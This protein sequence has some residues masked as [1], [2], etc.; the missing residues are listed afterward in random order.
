MKRLRYMVWGGVVAGVLAGRAEAQQSYPVQNMN[1]DMWCQEEKQLPPARCDK[2][3]PADD[4]EFQA[5]RAKIE[6][7]EIPY[8]QREQQQE[9][10]N[11]VIIHGDP[12]DHP[13]EPSTSPSVAGS[14]P[15]T[16]VLTCSVVP[17]Q[18]AGGTPPAGG[19]SPSQQ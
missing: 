13:T 2:R 14:T 6:K 1:F 15:C 3:L 18:N 5:Y 17:P 8:L 9:N 10:L 4:A 19:T 11:S 7:Y 16:G 12:I